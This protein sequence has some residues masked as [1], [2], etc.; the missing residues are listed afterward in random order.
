MALA[1][2]QQ[3][4]ACLEWTPKEETDRLQ[5][6]LFVDISYK[7]TL[8]WVLFMYSNNS[9]HHLPRLALLFAGGVIFVYLM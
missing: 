4:H 6:D 5:H 2:S 7:F 8:A 9:E 3:A 1:L